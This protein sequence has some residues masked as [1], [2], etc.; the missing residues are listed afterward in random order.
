MNNFMPGTRYVA[1]IIY[2]QW[3]WPFFFSVFVFVFLIF[4]VFFLR[5]GP[6]S[7]K[8]RL[9]FVLFFYDLFANF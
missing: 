1:L 2:T 7:P 9:F 3:S 8:S 6:S 4:S 5:H